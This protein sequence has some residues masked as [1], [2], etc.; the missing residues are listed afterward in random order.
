MLST[1]KSLV[2]ASVLICGTKWKNY[3]LAANSELPF[4]GEEG[5]DDFGGYVNFQGFSK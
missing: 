4:D 5:K 2:F 1:T 3:G